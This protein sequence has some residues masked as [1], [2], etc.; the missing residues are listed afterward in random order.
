MLSPPP[1][2][3]LVMPPSPFSRLNRNQRSIPS[4]LPP[5]P[6]RDMNV[7]PSSK[8]MRLSG[9]ALG[10]FSRSPV[11]TGSLRRLRRSLSRTHTRASMR[12]WARISPH[13][14]KRSGGSKLR[15]S[16]SPTRNQSLSHHR[17]S[18]SHGRER[19]ASPRRNFVKSQVRSI[20]RNQKSS[21]SCSAA[22]RSS[23]KD[24]IEHENPFK[25]R[26]VCNNYKRGPWNASPGR[27][28]K[29]FGLRSNTSQSKSP[30]RS[31]GSRDRGHDGDV[32]SRS[33]SRTSVESSRNRIP[34]RRSSSAENVSPYRET[35][36]SSNQRHSLSVRRNFYRTP[37]REY[38][39]DQSPP[40]NFVRTRLLGR[41]P[42][43]PPAR[44][45]NSPENPAVNNSV[46][47]PKSIS[48]SPTRSVDRMS[49]SRSCEARPSV[50]RSPR[51]SAR[52][53]GS[54]CE[55]FASSQKIQLNPVLRD[56]RQRGS[57]SSSPSTSRSTSSSRTPRQ[58][59]EKPVES[60]QKS[61][62][63][64]RDLDKL[65]SVKVPK[66]GA[67]KSS[68]SPELLQSRASQ[69]KRSHSVES[70]NTSR[71]RVC[72][73]SRGGP[74]SPS[75]SPDLQ[76]N[77]H[78]HVLSVSNVSRQ[79]RSLS[80]KSRN[81]NCHSPRSPEASPGRKTPLAYQCPRE[82]VS[83]PARKKEFQHSKSPMN[84]SPQL[85][86]STR[87]LRTKAH[88]SRHNR[89]LSKY[90]RRG[91][92]PAK[93]AE[94]FKKEYRRSPSHQD[95]HRVRYYKSPPPPLDHRHYRMVEDEMA[96]RLE[97]SRAS[98]Y[99][100]HHLDSRGSSYYRRSEYL[101]ESD[102]SY[103]RRPSPASH[104]PPP[105]SYPYR[106]LQEVPYQRSRVRCE[107]VDQYYRATDL[108]R[109]RIH[110]PP[111]VYRSGTNGIYSRQRLYRR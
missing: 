103:Y 79:K 90:S 56:C 54:R 37:E 45:T 111:V 68:V 7:S 3:T 100:D 41:T 88:P 42:P 101:P 105:P 20:K 14:I 36:R 62:E 81:S 29:P 104:L 8:L 91:A 30:A 44:N 39:R 76:S 109:G 74:R 66:Q 70:N 40:L 107:E 86:S 23:G 16:T 27:S 94:R 59:N 77:K 60:P 9:T 58:R 12:N 22:T 25:D 50:N 2:R 89:E 71:K 65:K 32:R 80:S 6:S 31:L 83:P 15:R 38:S 24:E 92:S 13:R 51:G 95:R 67:R 106:R 11:R 53:G 108:Y 78:S 99:E 28:K 4:L 21:R 43:S 72:V 63:V 49:R 97:R 35:S 1:K 85:A 93:E 55:S 61:P 69:K 98:Y 52:T 110:N 34:R 48:N 87:G 33:S 18:E 47:R 46:V 82:S 102:K 19:S 26:D 84:K 57:A 96:M 10:R 73:R 75:G 17:R 64:D 5:P